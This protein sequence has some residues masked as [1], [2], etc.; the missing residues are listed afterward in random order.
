[1]VFLPV[2]RFL[3]TDPFLPLSLTPQR[4]LTDEVLL[5][6]F[7]GLCGVS[8]LALGL[9]GLLGRVKMT[10]G[11]SF[12]ALLPVMVLSLITVIAVITMRAGQAQ[13]NAPRGP[14]KPPGWTMRNS[15]EWREFESKVGSNKPTQDGAS[16]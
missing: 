7:Q 12:V 14:P 8:A 15:K 1:M 10:Y 3:L 11:V 4:L 9:C 13:Q 5:L 6:V 2:F 16:L